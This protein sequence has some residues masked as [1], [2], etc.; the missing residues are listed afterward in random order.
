[1]PCSLCIQGFCPQIER[2]RD[3]VRFQEVESAIVVRSLPVAC[4]PKFIS[5][6]LDGWMDGWIDR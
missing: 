3:G 5:A 2:N 1:M 4:D 6:Q